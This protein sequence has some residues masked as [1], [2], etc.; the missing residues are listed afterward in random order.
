MYET[1]EI[2]G[3]AVILRTSDNTCIPVDEG[4]KDYQQYLID[5]A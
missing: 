3:I 2:N 4:N 1:I 5:T